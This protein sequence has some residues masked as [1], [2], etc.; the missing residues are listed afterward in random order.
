MIY[1]VHGTILIARTWFLTRE[2]NEMRR[3]S[4]MSRLAMSCFLTEK[5]NQMPIKEAI[6][7]HESVGED[8]AANSTKDFLYLQGMLIPY[9][10]EKL[11]DEIYQLFKEPMSAIPH[12]I[13]WPFHIVALPL[14]FYMTT[15][16]SRLSFSPLV[17]PPCEGNENK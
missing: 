7:R 10:I 3:T 16:L 6:E 13:T 2:N 5:G 11:Q 14:V 4:I 12:F 8:C 15:C 1:L 17:P 9:R